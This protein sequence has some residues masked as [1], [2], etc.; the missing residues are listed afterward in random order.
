M[1]SVQNYGMTNYQV[2][3][4]A[5]GGNVVKTLDDKIKKNKLIKNLT[6]ELNYLNRQEAESIKERGFLWTSASGISTKIANIE[7]RLNR[8]A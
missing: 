7:N 6:K 3:F 5:K 2:G 4:K 1:N 8:L